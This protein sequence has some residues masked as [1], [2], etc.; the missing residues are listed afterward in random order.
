MT[1]GMIANRDVDTALAD[2]S[3]QAAA[4]RMGT[5]LVGTLVV[6]DE[7]QRPTGMITDRD[8]AIR[9]VGKGRDPHRTSV[10]EVMTHDVL[11]AHEDLEVEKALA[12]MRANTIR[13][14]PVVDGSERLV[15]MVSLDDILTLLAREFRELGRL[16]SQEKPA[17]LRKA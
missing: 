12:L 8:I 17:I 6:L 14:L 3:I 1:I 4:Q 11:V 10:G 2:E 13:R 9:V 15:G 5:R 7:Q 16:L